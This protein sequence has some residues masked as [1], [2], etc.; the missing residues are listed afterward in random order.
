MAHRREAQRHARN[1][2]KSNDVDAGFGQL[3]HFEEWRRKKHAAEGN[4]PAGEGD[5]LDSVQPIP[6]QPGSK[7]QTVRLGQLAWTELSTKDQ[8]WDK[9]MAVGAALAVGREEA[10][11]LAGTNNPEG[12]NY[13]K[14][15]G[16]W[17]KQHGFDKIDKG[18]RSRLFECGEH[19]VEIE[20]WRATLT[21]GERHLLPAQM[22]STMSSAVGRREWWP[23]P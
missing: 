23:G 19:R 1:S 8:Q 20:V 5:R 13:N 14:C 12:K 22:T 7:E 10:M 21:L 9:W 4:Q 2:Q 15:F 3:D 16:D 11:Y 17:L 6:V 18:D